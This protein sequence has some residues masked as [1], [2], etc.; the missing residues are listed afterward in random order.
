MIASFCVSRSA[1]PIEQV[2]RRLSWSRLLCFFLV[3]LLLDI[4]NMCNWLENT[5]RTC[6]YWRT[7]KKNMWLI[8]ENEDIIV[9][10]WVKRGENLKRRVNYSLCHLLLSKF[11]FGSTLNQSFYFRP[12]NFVIFFSL[13]HLT[14][15]TIHTYPLFWWRYGLHIDRKFTSVSK[16]IWLRMLMNVEVVWSGPN[17][18]QNYKVIQSKVK[19][20]IQG[21]SKVKIGR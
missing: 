9:S 18:K 17:Q 20:L 11:R 6:Q 1:K 13:D 12:D 14:L 16:P 15:F 19:R 7:L 2:E 8:E 3:R 10:F 21:W 5:A 4:K